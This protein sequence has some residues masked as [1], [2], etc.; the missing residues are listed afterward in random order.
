LNLVLAVI[1][2]TQFCEH[3]LKFG[4][5]HKQWFGLLIP[6]KA[7]D[8]A[9]SL[10]CIQINFSKAIEGSIPRMLPGVPDVEAGLP[11]INVKK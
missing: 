7:Q 3:I 9:A 11:F 6:K 10:K 1:S 2:G 4:K 8:T 5:G